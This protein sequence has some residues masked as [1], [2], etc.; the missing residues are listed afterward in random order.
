MWARCAS[1][2]V[3]IA[4]GTL[5]TPGCARIVV[6][7]VERDDALGIRFN[8]PRPYVLRMLNEKS[9]CQ[10][11]LVWLPDESQE[12][13]ISVE[14][15]LGTV[16]ANG[17]LANGW[18]LTSFGEARDSRIPETIEALT[19][20]LATGAAIAAPATAAKG[21]TGRGAAPGDCVPALYEFTRDGARITG[22]RKL[23]P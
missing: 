14:S 16:S 20:T 15:G 6:K 5:G 9:G 3:A 21:A 19:G 12:Y 11:L 13:A 18:N 17:T 1:I 4:L 7:R 23:G 22:I 8:R 10:D 2:F